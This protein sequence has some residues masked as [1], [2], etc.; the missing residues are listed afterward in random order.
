MKI[1]KRI[2]LSNHLFGGV[3]KSEGQHLRQQLEQEFGRALTALLISEMPFSNSVL[4]RFI[5]L[6]LLRFVKL[7]FNPDLRD[8]LGERLVELL[9]EFLD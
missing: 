8:G 2:K 5:L 9:T 1:R 3:L 6:L 4:R 7:R